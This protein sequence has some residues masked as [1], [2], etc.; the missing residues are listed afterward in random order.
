[1]EL[2]QAGNVY[3]TQ[4]YWN[5]IGFEIECPFCLSKC[6]AFSDDRVECEEDSAHTFS[7]S[8]NRSFN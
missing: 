2:W 3:K 5:G 4:M 1:M 6:Y 8:L 7:L